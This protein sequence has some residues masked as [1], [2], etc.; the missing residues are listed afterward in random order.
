M[1]LSFSSSSSSSI[2]HFSNTQRW[3]I[4]KARENGNP[5]PPPLVPK[6]AKEKNSM[7]AKKA[8][9]TEMKPKVG[10][11]LPKESSTTGDKQKKSNK[12]SVETYCK[13]YVF[14]VLKQVHPDTGISCKAT[15]SLI[16]SSMTSSRSSIKNLRGSLAITRIRRSCR[17]RFKPL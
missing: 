10:K 3:E 1:S 12:K 2:I 4:T 11:K 14:K 5:K 15:G 17:V 8:P 7:V 6:P 13:I 16:A 9:S